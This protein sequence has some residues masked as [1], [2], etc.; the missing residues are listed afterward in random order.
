MIHLFTCKKYVR[1]QLSWD[2][3][4]ISTKQYCKAGATRA[5]GLEIGQCCGV[6]QHYH[7]GQEKGGRSNTSTGGGSQVCYSSTSGTAGSVGGREVQET[8]LERATKK[9]C[10][11]LIV[12]AV[13]GMYVTFFS[14]SMI[15]AGP[16]LLYYSYT[17]HN[18]FTETAFSTIS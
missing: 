5:K 2:F 4:T 16:R 10:I 6:R 3:S 14:N 18:T 17:C 15:I 1:K 7:Q 8:Q 11:K 12:S 9:K 13:N